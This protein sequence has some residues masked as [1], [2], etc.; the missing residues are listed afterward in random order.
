ML[1]FI[2]HERYK[3]NEKCIVFVS[4]RGS[5]E[6]KKNIVNSGGQVREYIPSTHGQ[7]ETVTILDEAE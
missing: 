6:G 5:G 2:T 7:P 4:G 1:A 3:C